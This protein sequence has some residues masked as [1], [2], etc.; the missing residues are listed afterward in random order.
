MDRWI[1]YFGGLASLALCIS[2][3]AFLVPNG[4][5]L[6]ADSPSVALDLP[7][8]GDFVDAEDEA[9]LLDSIVLC[10]QQFE[11]TSFHFCFASYEPLTGPT[12]V[13]E[14]LK[15]ELIA[16]VGQLPFAHYFSLVAYNC[17]TY[18]WP[19]GAALASESSID[20]AAA[21]IQSLETMAVAHVTEAGLMSLNLGSLS[22]SPCF[23]FIGSNQPV[24]P[25]A[26]E[27]LT[28]A[29]SASGRAINV[30]YVPD[31]PGSTDGLEW[32]HSLAAETGG[33]FQVVE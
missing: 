18:V 9:P 31:P 25:Y 6:A 33:K 28:T 27:T 8:G 11:G 26:L 21:W 17:Y 29:A 7:S 19:L 12:G 16:A 4:T 13:E 3:S 23:I 1:V 5:I 20:Y 30:L 10:G 32:W 14:T 15:E 2:L 22:D 24:D